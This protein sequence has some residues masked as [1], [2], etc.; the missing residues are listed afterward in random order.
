MGGREQDRDDPEGRESHV[1]RPHQPERHRAGN[2]Q[3]LVGRGSEAAP[4]EATIIAV[5]AQREPR[6]VAD[7]TT[8]VRE[9][10]ELLVQVIKD[11]LGS[12][13]A[14]LTTYVSM[15][16]CYLVFMPGAENVGVSQRIEDEEERFWSE[17][18]DEPT[19]W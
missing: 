19:E 7:I 6:Q 16:S 3:R 15:P 5:E 12:K 14:R 9:N 2:G 17:S 1:R 4:G 11:P 10:Q 13:G 18:W 8:L